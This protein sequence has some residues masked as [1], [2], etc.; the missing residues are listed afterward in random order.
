MSSKSTSEKSSQKTILTIA[1][2]PV[3]RPFQRNSVDI[4]EYKSE[5]ISAAGVKCKI[6]LSMMDNLTRFTLLKPIPNKAAETVA[7]AIID[8]IIGIF[9]TPE[10]LHSDRGPEFEN[11]VISQLQS[12]LGYKKTRTTPYVSFAGELRFRACTLTNTRHAQ[13]GARQLGITLTAS[14][15]GP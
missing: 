1:H 2:L 10:I 6:V 12:I 15:I 11:K 8:R 3:D 7:R 9:G 13:H 4:F 14:T 5:S